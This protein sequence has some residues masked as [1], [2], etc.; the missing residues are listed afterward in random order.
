M[1]KTNSWHYFES[2]NE[3]EKLGFKLGKGVESALK[4]FWKCNEYYDV[5]K[6]QDPRLHSMFNYLTKVAVDLNLGGIDPYIFG[7]K[8]AQYFY[9]SRK[10]KRFY[11]GFLGTREALEVYLNYVNSIKVKKQKQDM[12]E[13]K[14]ILAKV[15]N[16]IKNAWNLNKE[17]VLDL[18]E[19]GG[20]IDRGVRKDL[21]HI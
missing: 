15:V 3:E 1:S 17:E 14:K 7:Y 4:D 9:S 10:G 16:R 12:E 6:R 5:F 21:E 18:L 8:V 2:L 11:F 13:E 19:E 20:K